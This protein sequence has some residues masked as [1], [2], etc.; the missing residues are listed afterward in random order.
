MK[1][2][3]FV[4]QHLSPQFEE[5]VKQWESEGFVVMKYH[6]RGYS[7]HECIRKAEEQIGIYRKDLEPI[8]SCTS[9]FMDYV[10]TAVKCK[11]KEE[12]K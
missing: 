3:E 9:I 2:T 1:N 6:S 10:A 4:V 12:R 5:L 7:V 8:E 11:V